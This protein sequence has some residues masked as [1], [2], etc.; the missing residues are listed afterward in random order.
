M[1][2]HCYV[3]KYKNYL[4]KTKILKDR[5]TGSIKEFYSYNSALRL[6]NWLQENYIV[7]EKESTKKIRRRQAIKICLAY[8]LSYR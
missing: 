6:K 2:D 5:L 1:P 4:G 3:V 7:H 8:R